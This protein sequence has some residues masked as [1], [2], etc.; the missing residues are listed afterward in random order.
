MTDSGFYG[1]LA[2]FYHLV[3]SDWEASVSR[4]ASAL[5]AI[6]RAADGTR[7][8]SVLDAA[9]G[10]GTQ[11]LGLAA[12]GYR[13]TASDLSPGAV[14][15]ARREAERR[16]LDVGFSV[17]DMREVFDHHGRTF[18]V[19]LAAD[20]S[21]PHLLSDAEILRAFR[22]FFSCTRPG[23]VCVVSVRDYA[24]EERGGTRVVPHGVRVEDGVRYLVFQLWEW[25]GEL[26]DVS[27]YLVE[28]RP[29]SEPVTRVMR[30]T[31]YAVSLD[32]LAELMTRVGF[33]RVRR[34]DGVF[35]QPV[36]VGRRPPA[37]AAA[38]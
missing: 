23:G 32:T 18:D 5:D 38:G 12:L 27:L 6:I 30:S 31:Y 29:G 1:E 10:I 4:Q 2:P 16:E 28:D 8:G 11:S 19:V 3:Y 26:Y 33:E 25:R 21:V 9:C 35:F 17:A 34:I 36:L 37:D 22:Q 14:E 20:N 13:V 7:E 24:V 15:R